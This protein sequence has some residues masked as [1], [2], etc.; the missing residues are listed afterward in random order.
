MMR[1]RSITLA[2]LGLCL[3]T[4]AGAAEPAATQRAATE[5]VFHPLR[6]SLSAMA[7]PFSESVRAGDMLYL[8]GQIGTDATG[9]LVAGGIRAEAKQ[10][11]D[12]IGAALARGGSSFT[13]VVQCTVAL[14][15]IAEWPA[16]NEV[17]RGYFTK[18]YP[19][20]MAFAATGLALGARVEV[21]CNAV[22]S[23]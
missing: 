21:Q 22:V 1:H 3:A 11:M 13:G 2:L 19:A 9:K 15:D 23:R 7:P 20:R 5:P 18:R 12:N 17:Y 4:Q 10:T 8:S 16:F 6:G 14:V